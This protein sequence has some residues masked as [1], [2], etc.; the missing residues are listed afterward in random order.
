[1]PLSHPLTGMGQP[2]ATW[3]SLVHLV[4]RHNQ[5]D[6]SRS[7][8]LARRTSKWTRESSRT[9]G[10]LRSTANWANSVTRCGEW[11]HQRKEAIQSP[12]V[13]RPI[14]YTNCLLHGIMQRR[15]YK[16]KKSFDLSHRLRW[17]QVVSLFLRQIQQTSFWPTGSARLRA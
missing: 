9:L 7:I 13:T 8:C 6:F 14:Y 3:H 4:H 2:P 17:Y 12:V 11:S 10:V 1:M 16:Q 15:V 5:G